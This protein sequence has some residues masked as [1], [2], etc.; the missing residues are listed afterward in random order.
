MF[1]HYLV[2]MACIS[3]FTNNNFALLS[4]HA[5][6]LVLSQS[7]GFTNRSDACPFNW[8]EA[9][10]INKRQYKTGKVPDYQTFFYYPSYIQVH[11]LNCL[12]SFCTHIKIH[13]TFKI[14][15]IPRFKRKMAVMCI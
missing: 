4:K 8:L 11:N 9:G 6:P 13:S 1:L 10:V 3:L 15:G 14:W 2:C 5:S 12:I 7:H